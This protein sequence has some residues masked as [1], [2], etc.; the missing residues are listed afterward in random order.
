MGLCLGLWGVFSD[1][2]AC[3]NYLFE[4]LQKNC[5]FYEVYTKMALKYCCIFRCLP[6]LHSMLVFSVFSFLFFLVF[7]VNFH[8]ISS[9]VLILSFQFPSFSSIS[10]FTYYF[11]NAVIHWDRLQ[12]L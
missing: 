2:A 9:S 4:E 8:F 1:L 11:H 7:F 6:D 3:F 12:A 5:E 10:L